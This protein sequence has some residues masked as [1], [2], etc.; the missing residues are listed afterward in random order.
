[1]T[2]WSPRG[3]V[4]SLILSNSPK[5]FFKKKY[6]EHSGEFA[7]GYWEI[8]GKV[9]AVAFC[10]PGHAVLIVLRVQMTVISLVNRGSSLDMISKKKCI[11]FYFL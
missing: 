3:N 11:W 1:M 5:K 7:C 10:Y 8:K 2:K 6:G 9:Y 4:W